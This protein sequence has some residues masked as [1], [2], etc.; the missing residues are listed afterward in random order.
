MLKS[1]IAKSN[2]S[3]SKEW[4][5]TVHQSP[6]NSTASPNDFSRHINLHLTYSFQHQQQHQ[7]QQQP[8][9]SPAT[10]KSPTGSI[11]H[12]HGKFVQDVERRRA[13]KTSLPNN[14]SENN[15]NW[16]FMTWNLLTVQLRF[17]FLNSVL[18]IGTVDGRALAGLDAAVYA[19]RSLMRTAAGLRRIVNTCVAL[20]VSYVEKYARLEENYLPTHS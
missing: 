20:K 7:Q 1:V 15:R 9:H 4:I 8:Q 5:F 6:P 10:C 13:I 3:A 18:R 14:I 17:C 12:N 16:R 19:E 11:Y 2:Q